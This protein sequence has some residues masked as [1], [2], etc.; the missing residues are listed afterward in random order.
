MYKQSIPRAIFYK[1]NVSR[2]HFLKSVD[3]TSIAPQETYLFAA[4]T[5]SSTES[6]VVLFVGSML[7]SGVCYSSN[8]DIDPPAAA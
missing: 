2:F 7:L 6:S 4:I 1:Q 5:I 8:R 3:S